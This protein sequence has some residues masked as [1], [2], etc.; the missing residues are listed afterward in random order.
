LE[1]Q[2]SPEERWVSTTLMYKDYEMK[3]KKSIKCVGASILLSFLSGCA[4]VSAKGGFQ[5]VQSVFKSRTGLRTHWNQG[6][7]EDEWVAETVNAMLD[8]KLSVGEA[9][10]IALLNNP[11]LQAEY[12]EL[13]IAQ[14]DLVQAG[15]LSN[16]I[17]SGSWRDPDGAG[18]TNTEFSIEQNFLDILF[19]P[20]NRKMAK[21]QLIQ[22][23][24][25]VG[26][27]LLN[28]T[29]DVRTA[30]Y[31]LQADNQMYILH[32]KY[33]QAA[34]A[35]AELAR[36]QF[37]AGNISPIDL[38]KRKADYHEL[39]LKLI[40]IKTEMRS[41]H[42]LLSRLMGLSESDY[43]WQIKDRLPLL[44][45]QMLQIENLEDV[46]IEQRLDLSAARQEIKIVKKS[47]KLAKFSFLSSLDIGV[48]TEEEPDGSSVTGPEVSLGV[49]LFDRGQASRAK[50]RARLKQSQ[51]KL[52][53]M[54]AEIRSEV[55]LL[56]DRMQT[57][58]K[59]VEYYIETIIPVHEEIVNLSQKEYNFMLHGVYTL[60]QDKQKEISVR[61]EYIEALKEYWIACSDLERAIGG[62]LSEHQGGK[63]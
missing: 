26:N 12:E 5:D 34:E 10:Q 21:E 15:L 16:P 40:Q 61:Q 35:A 51:E 32:E 48:S 31:E 22:T 49:P 23:K 58:R 8:E 20:L 41:K 54:E 14:A 4:S 57:A 7:S 42:E 46:A 18:K 52:K 39:R 13:G 38:A 17:F 27:A 43:D 44:P 45:E 53:A 3:V 6:T 60:L 50:A 19:L 11:T 36:R 25:L 62:R 59:S 29:S 37:D 1:G 56:S 55:R 28:F 30:Y 33:M 2:C 9:V 47:L 63:Q 24:Y